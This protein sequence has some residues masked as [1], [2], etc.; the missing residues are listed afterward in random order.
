MTKAFPSISE[1]LI[2]GNL[3]LELELMFSEIYLESMSDS[4]ITEKNLLEV[5]V[6]SFFHK[7]NFIRTKAL[8]LAKDLRTS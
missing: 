6:H 5:G 2:L 8:V 7:N 1:T 3:W 4:D